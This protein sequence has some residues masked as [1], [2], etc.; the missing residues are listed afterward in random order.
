MNSL[1]CYEFEREHK[2]LYEKM[3]SEDEEML[4]KLGIKTRN[5]NG[6]LRALTELFEDIEELEDK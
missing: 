3:K 1:T 5:K 6:K 4:N 2:K